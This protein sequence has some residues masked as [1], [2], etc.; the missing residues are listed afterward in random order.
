VCVFISFFLSRNDD[1]SQKPQLHLV[2][3]QLKLQ[4][5][6]EQNI[7]CISSQIFFISTSSKCKKLK[8]YEKQQKFHF[9]LFFIFIYF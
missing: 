9:L 6:S 4:K 7:I 1:V 8:G 5:F 3:Y 2:K